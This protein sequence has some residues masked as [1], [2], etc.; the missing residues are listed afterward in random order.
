MTSRERVSKIL[1]YAEAD[2]VAVDFS[3]HRSSGIAVQAYKKLRE[4]LGLEQSE[5]FVYDLIQQLAIV[6][7]DVLEIF[8]VDV[9][10]LGYN[11]Y[12]KPEFWKEWRLHDGTAV[13]IPSSV[14]ISVMPSG[15]YE[16]KTP[17]GEQMGIQ[18]KDCLYFEQTLFPYMEDRNDRF[19]DIEEQF[20]R[21]QWVGVECPPN[22]YSIEQ[23]GVEAK[24]LRA[25]TEKAIYGMFG[26]NLLELGQQAMRM[27]VFLM[28]LAGNPDRIERFLDKLFEMHMKNLEQYLTHI[29]P[30][31]DVIGVSDDLGMQ[32][33][34]QISPAMFGRVFKPRYAKMWRLIKQKA[35]HLKICMHNCGSIYALLP[36]L[37]DAGLDAVNPV[38]TTC[39]D[40]EPEKLKRNFDGKITFWGGGCDTREVLPNGTPEQVQENVKHN[41]EVFA[42]NG[43]FVFQQVHN[44]LADVP[45]ENIVAM[46]EAVKKYGSY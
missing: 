41:I 14:N 31:I 37:I 6:E 25:S 5:L 12:K 23:Q 22:Q 20:Q 13:K 32:D 28:E 26:G 17:S 2:R 24:A 38:Q 18:K 21:I 45:P 36:S 19:D 15:D 10:Q 7:D 30:H 11:F 8:G 16:I 35:P 4:Y 34:P 44:I 27:D 39:V 40:M 46:F 9:V 43:G 42:P 33:G 3:G 1:N 29:G